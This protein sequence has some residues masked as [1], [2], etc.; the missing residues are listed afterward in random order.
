MLKREISL[1]EHSLSACV[2]IPTVGASVSAMYNEDIIKTTF[3]Q[4]EMDLLCNRRD[5]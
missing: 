2:V 5:M 4:C 3:T 1:F